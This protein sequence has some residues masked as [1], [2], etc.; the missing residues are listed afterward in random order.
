MP[1]LAKPDYGIDAPGVLRGLFLSGTACLVAYAG[2]RSRGSTDLHFHVGPT[3]V[4]FDIGQTLFWTGVVVTVEAFLY[5]LYVKRGKLAHRDRMLGMHLWMS[6]EQVLDIG[7]GRGLLL[8]GAAKRLVAANGGHATGIDIWS[9]VDMAGNSAAA[10][11][12]NIDMEGVADRCSLA[13]MSAVKLDFPDA[14]FDVIVSNLCLHNIPRK[15]DR[16]QA[17]REIARV[18]KPGGQALISDYRRTGEYRRVFLAAGCNVNI[19]R[20]GWLRTFPPLRTL[21]VT[22]PAKPGPR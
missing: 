14:S 16:N 18:L 8:V 13:N 19:R 6:D 20:G 22:H 12:R 7:C 10:T 2:L 21:E 15:A 17:C 1:Q 9:Q 11:Q 4:N 3:T 5:L